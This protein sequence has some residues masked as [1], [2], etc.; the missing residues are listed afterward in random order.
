MIQYIDGGNAME[1]KTLQRKL[2]ER[3]LKKVPACLYAILMPV[4]KILGKKVNVHFTYKAYPAKDPDPFVLISN[5]ASRNDYL[6]T[7]PACLPKRLNYVVGYNEFFRFPLGL[8][9]R[10]MQVIPKKNFTPDFY[11]IKEILRVAQDGGNICFMPEGM[12]SI[13]GMCQPVIPG[14]G[15]LLKKLGRNVYYTKISGGYMTYTKHC[16]D[17]RKGRVEVVVDR[18]FTADELKTLTPEEI[19]ERMN[20]LLS[21]DDYIWNREAKVPFKVKGGMAQK[22]DTLLY[23]CPACGSMYEMKTEGNTMTCLHCG[24]SIVM[25]EYCSIRPADEKSVCP[26]LVT[27]WTLM[28]RKKAREDVMKDGF[29]HS[30]HVKIG[31]LP[32]YRLLTGGKTSEICG[33]GILT[34]DREGLHFRGKKNGEDFSFDLS[35]DN[36]PTYGMCTDISRLY[37]FVDGE[38]VE[39]YFD[40]GD[41]LRWDHLTEELHRVNGGKWQDTVYRHCD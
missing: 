3:K 6:F 5:H 34:L 35:S 2:H 24:N 11:T 1:K 39:F 22:L 41:V 25:D 37:T 28:E 31:M 4:V 21:H 13:T 9:L 15:K 14:G 17:E 40:D 12:S 19:E 29:T 30:E 33:D 36:V 23:M 26:E 8:L 38:F 20:E 18:M 32:E 7:A 10:W 27:D 16:L